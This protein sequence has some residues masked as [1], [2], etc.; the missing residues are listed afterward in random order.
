VVLS[1]SPVF[2]AMAVVTTYY[3]VNSDD[4]FESSLCRVCRACCIEGHNI[5]CVII[6]MNIDSSASIVDLHTVTV[7][8]VDDPCSA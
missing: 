2:V 5:L 8:Y 1:G 7:A 3:T 6:F 4:L